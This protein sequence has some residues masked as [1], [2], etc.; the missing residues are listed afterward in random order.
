MPITAACLLAMLLLPFTKKMEAWGANSM[1]AAIASMI[2]LILIITVVMFLLVNRIE[3]FS[4]DLPKL[5]ENFEPK[6]EKAEKFISQKT[7]ISPWNQEEKVVSM[8]RR[9]SEEI[10]SGTMS[11]VSN[12]P[13][14]LMTGLLVTVYTFFFILYRG[15]FTKFVLKLVRD[16]DRERTE[17]I[18]YNSSKVAQKYLLGRLTLIIL[19]GLIYYVGFSILGLSHSIFISTLAAALSIIPYIGNMLAVLLAVVLGLMNG[20]G[21]SGLLGIVIIFIFSQLLE[22]YILTPYIA[23]SQVNLNAV[24]S[25]LAIVFGSIVWGISG[26]ILALPVVG[27]VKV[28]CDNVPQLHPFGYLLGEESPSSLQ[29]MKNLLAKFSYRFH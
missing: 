26:A 11:I 18:I 19:L 24:I 16:Q 9:R 14:F 27:I 15:K 23:G 20:L 17:H 5:F 21:I 4:K 3:A 10:T 7:G 13:G 22:S 29:S 2:L 25:I 8:L 6:I 1:V 28:I 12:V